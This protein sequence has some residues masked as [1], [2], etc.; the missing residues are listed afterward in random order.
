MLTDYSI[1]STIYG[2]ANIYPLL[3]SGLLIVSLL[4]VLTAFLPYL[5][6]ICALLVLSVFSINGLQFTVFGLQLNFIQFYFLTTLI[7]IFLKY[8]LKTIDNLKENLSNKLIL[9]VILI[10]CISFITISIYNYT[11]FSSFP[12]FYLRNNIISLF[13]LIGLIVPKDRMYNKKL[14]SFYGIAF[15]LLLIL[16]MPSAIESY[17]VLEDTGGCGRHHGVGIPELKWSKMN[18]TTP[19]IIDNSNMMIQGWLYIDG[20]SKDYLM[21]LYAGFVAFVF[22]WFFLSKRSVLQ[23]IIFFGSFNIIFAFLYINR[24][25]ST[26]MIFYILNAIFLG[27]LIYLSKK[28]I[29]KFPFIKASLLTLNT[30]LFFFLTFSAARI[31]A[32]QAGPYIDEKI[33]GITNLIAQFRSNTNQVFADSSIYQAPES[34]GHTAENSGHTAESSGHTA[35]SSGHMDDTHAVAKK[36]LSYLL[37]S[38]TDEN[39]IN[40]FSKRLVYIKDASESVNRTTY[41]T[42]RLIKLINEYPLTG[43]GFPSTYEELNDPKSRYYAAI[44]GHSHQFD[45]LAAFGIPLGLLGNYIFICP[46]VLIFYLLKKKVFPHDEIFFWICIFTSTILAS[47]QG[48]FGDQASQ[49]FI[50]FFLLCQFT[51]RASSL[52]I[53]CPKSSKDRSL[54]TVKDLKTIRIEDFADLKN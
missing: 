15:I 18:L 34:S 9:S 23:H 46:F 51:I 33:A 27:H 54:Y 4:A 7:F 1:L 11:A 35:E 12:S 32:W 41:C 50:Q 38:I 8:R 2:S 26:I 16:Y 31:S 22:R 5:L 19:L 42:I 53:T 28:Q 45:Q 52:T 36:E 24:F 13:A 47:A 10:Y 48:K 39:N 49:L 30:F 20:N 29:A 43:A 25:F 44:S 21:I 17:S 37:S 3:Y 6:P 40:T 14:V